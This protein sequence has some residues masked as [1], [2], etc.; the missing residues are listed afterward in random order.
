MSANESYNYGPG[1]QSA[2]VAIAAKEIQGIFVS[3]SS[4]GVLAV[5]D[6][7][8]SGGTPIVGSVSVVAGTFYRMPFRTMTNSV[9]IQLVSGTATFTAALG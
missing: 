4:S 5:F 1:P 7:T 6:G 2:S 3:A 8:S 9:Y